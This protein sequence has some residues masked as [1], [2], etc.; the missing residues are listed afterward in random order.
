MT[1]CEG[2]FLC[3]LMAFRIKV[4]FLPS[5]LTLLWRDANKLRTSTLTVLKQD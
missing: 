4:V 3:K 5:S 2:D 1:L